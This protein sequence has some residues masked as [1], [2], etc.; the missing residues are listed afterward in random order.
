MADAAERWPVSVDIPVAWGEMDAFQ[1]VNNVVYARW[2]ETAR[3]EYFRQVGFLERMRDD[4]VGPIL[5]RLSIDFRRPVTYPDTVRVS[6]RT[7][8]LGSRSFTMEFTVA[9]LDQ[10]AEVARGDQ[11]IVVFD[12][13]AGATAAIDDRLR[14]AIEAL[15]GR[16][17]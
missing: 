8:R 10:G 4:G 17:P 5:A 15:E 16:A 12:Y 3:I 6:V 9:S 7:S 1:H 11:V 14:G 13:R 2:A